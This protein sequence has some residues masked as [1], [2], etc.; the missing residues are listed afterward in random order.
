MT[1]LRSRV[2]RLAH[3]HPDLQPHLLPILTAGKKVPLSERPIADQVRFQIG[4]ARNWIKAGGPSSAKDYLT[5]G[6]ALA[7][8]SDVIGPK[9]PALV[10]LLQQASQEL[11]HNV[12]PWVAG[13]LL[14]QAIKLLPPRT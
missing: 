9:T 6:L 11:A 12:D 3:E 2:I 7:R 10:R 8:Q 13:D 5:R 14:E 4:T 1:T